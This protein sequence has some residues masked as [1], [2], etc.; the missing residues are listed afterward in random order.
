MSCFLPVS[1]RLV[2]N[3]GGRPYTSGGRVLNLSPLEVD[4]LSPV[5]KVH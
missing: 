4:C 2:V 5:G 3:N 1:M